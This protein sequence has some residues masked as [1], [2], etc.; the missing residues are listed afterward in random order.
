MS[1]FDYPSKAL[2]EDAPAGEYPLTKVGLELFHYLGGIYEPLGMEGSGRRSLNGPAGHLRPKV[3]YR[4]QGLVI[5]HDR[6]V[7]AVAVYNLMGQEIKKYR[8]AEI[9][10]IYPGSLGSGIYLIQIRDED[11]SYCTRI[12]IPGQ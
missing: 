1:W 9:N 11:T 8:R 5:D 12:F 3:Y 7:K 4:D 6:P 10:N 2:P